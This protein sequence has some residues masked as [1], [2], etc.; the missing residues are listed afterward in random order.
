MSKKKFGMPSI[1]LTLDGD[2][3]SGDIIGGGT[4]T[5]VPGDGGEGGPDYVDYMDYDAWLAVYGNLDVDG[6]GLGGT[7]D[8]WVAW[9]LANGYEPQP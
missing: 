7:E 3:G 6:D 8:D 5:G 4:G 9:L 2:E 1:I